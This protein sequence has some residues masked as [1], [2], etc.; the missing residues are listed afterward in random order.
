MM[1]L[2]TSLHAQLACHSQG[3]KNVKNSCCLGTFIK[4]S[5]TSI[6]PAV[7]R[8]GLQIRM[9]KGAGIPEVSGFGSQRAGGKA[10]HKL[11][12]LDP[13][14][15]EEV[16][17]FDLYARKFTK[18]EPASKWEPIGEILVE[19]ETN[20]ELALK[21]RRKKLLAAAQ[22]QHPSFLM[23]SAG[24]EVQ[25]GYRKAGEEKNETDITVVDVKGKDLDSSI[26]AL[27]RV[28]DGVKPPPKRY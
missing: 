14:K 11:L 18:D 8:R 23:L 16:Q 9:L 21:E 12:T 20:L 5:K 13:A 19:K 17:K 26:P 4:T 2:T 25:Y 3:I 28:D 1:T 15:V 6:S 10:K 24:E 7:K 27:L 22:H